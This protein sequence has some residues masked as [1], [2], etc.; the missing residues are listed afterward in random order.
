MGKGKPKDRHDGKGNGG[1][2]AS[3]RNPGLHSPEGQSLVLGWPEARASGPQGE[4][5]GG[6]EVGI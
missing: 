2:V 4:A 6:P 1:K 5:P 3:K